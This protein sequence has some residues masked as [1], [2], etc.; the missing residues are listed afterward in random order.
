M[1]T[2]QRDVADSTLQP[3]DAKEN[4]A[5]ATTPSS[6]MKEIIENLRLQLPSHVQFSYNNYDRERHGRGESYHPVRLPDAVI[7]PASLEDVR[8]IV[9]FCYEHRVPLIPFGAGTSVEGHVC[10]LRGGVSLDMGQFHYIQVPDLISSSVTSLSNVPDLYATV[11]AGVTRKQLNKALRHTGLHFTV[12]PGADATLG[13]MAA[14]GASGTTTVRYGGMRENLLELEVVVADGPVPSVVRCGTKALKNSAG[15]DLLSLFC[16]SEGTLGV[17][18]SATVRLHPVPDHTVAVTCQFESL[19]AAADVVASLRLIGGG[20]LSRCELL[21]AESVNAFNAYNKCQPSPMDVKP[22]LFLEFQGPGPTVVDE[23]VEAT[24][25]LCGDAG[26]TGFAHAVTDEE[27]TALW[28]ARHS[29]YYASIAHRPGAT[30]AI[31]TD[32]CVPLSKFADLI[33]ATAADVLEQGVVGPCFGHASDG[34]LHCI[35]PVRD[36]D[37]EEYLDRLQSV[38]SNLIDRTLSAGGTCTGEHG[39][40]YGKIRYLERQYGPGAVGAMMAIKRSLDPRNIMNPGK[41]VIVD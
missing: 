14:T 13:G 12:D 3:D 28:N 24:S 26:G 22:T 29:L 38:Q 39:I 32:C 15:Y 30:G 25:G 21:D 11:G 37:S 33:E 9:G 18:T 5:V 10:A 20:L 4:E 6:F 17:I 36:D 1:T 7:S 19:H 27:R 2:S 34:N 41:I 31:V 35:L 40:G 8:T 23:L 16:G